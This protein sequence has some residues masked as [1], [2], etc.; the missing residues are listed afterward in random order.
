[1]KIIYSPQYDGEIFLGDRPECFDTLYVGNMGLLQ[2]LGL[3]AGIYMESTSD[4]EREVEY[5]KAM[6]PLLKGTCFET[7]AETDP[8]GVAAKLLLW[9]DNLVMAGWDGECDNETLTKLH[10]LAKIEQEFRKSANYMGSADYW[11]T[12]CQHYEN[13]A[14]IRPP[15]TEVQIDCPMSEIP[16]L[17]QRTFTALQKKGVDFL[18]TVEESQPQDLQAEKIKVVQFSDL[19]EAYEWV[20]QVALPDNCAIVNR[21]NVRLDH[22]LYTW[23]R[24][25]VHA[26]FNRSNPQLLQLFKLS[27]SVFSRPLNLGNLISY[28]QLPDGPIP[29]GLRNKLASILLKNGGFGDEIARDD[30]QVRD[31]WNEAIRTY[32]FID[33][34]KQGNPNPGDS[35]KVR[36]AKMSFLNPIREDLSSG[37]NKSDLNDYVLKMQEWIGGFFGCDDL[38]EELKK[39]LH[40]LFSMFSAFKKAIENLPNTVFYSDIEKIVL[41]IYRPMNYT[42]RQSEQGALNVIS[43]IRSMVV[44]ADTLVWLDCQAE[45]VER[46]PYDF[47]SA[48]ERNYLQGKKVQIPDFATHLKVRRTERNRLLNSVKKNVVLVQSDYNGIRR[49]GEHSLVAEVKHLFGEKFLYADAKE[50][51]AITEPVTKLRDI[52]TFKSQMYYDVDMSAFNGRKESNSS[53]ETLIQRPFNYVMKY[54]AELPTPKDEQVKSPYITLGLVAHHFFQHVI[55]DGKK[56]ASGPELYDYLRNLTHKQFDIYLEAAINAT[57]LILLAEENATQLYNFRWQLKQ[58]MLKLVDI[59]EHLD[60]QPEGCEIDVPAEDHDVTLPVIG[61]F[62]AR[63]DF[64]LTDSKGD[65]VVI[66]FK[67]SSSKRYPEKLENNT[68]I[69]L[70]L[71]R[72]AVSNFYEKEVKGVGYYMMPKQQLFTTDFVSWN[73]LIVNVSSSSV[74]LFDQIQNSFEFRKKELQGGHIEEGELMELIGCDYVNAPSGSNLFTLEKDKKGKKASEYVFR[75]TKKKTFDFDKKEPNETLTSHPILKGRLK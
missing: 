35:P 54:V 47:L 56:A 14:S 29:R 67:W 66:D 60:L 19:Q 8:I 39:Q 71:Y 7:S 50:I 59:M 25:A 10:V 46:D 52:D 20:T 31:D 73:N 74:N 72:Q 69:Q 34:D 27:L 16:H 44:P 43:D 70:E 28:L 2:Q 75:P 41:R 9:R 53:I 36:A 5:Q 12:I 33:F 68:S 65:Y 51:F 64:L 63:I 17:V 37:I 1:M 6:A 48:A 38:P 4:M 30:E 13:P 61:S 49:L 23:D 24:P 22:V 57:G 40:E 58:S 21:D 42:W 11:R 55:E 15:I 62:G 18:W 3:R 32:E 45:D 26:S